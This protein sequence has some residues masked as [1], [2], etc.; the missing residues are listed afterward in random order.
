MLKTKESV[1]ADSLFFFICQVCD[2][3]VYEAFFGAKTYFLAGGK[4]WEKI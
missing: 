1:A 2:E 4:E 3:K